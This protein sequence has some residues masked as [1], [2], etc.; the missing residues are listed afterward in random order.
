MEHLNELN[1]ANDDFSLIDFDSINSIELL[2]YYKL[3]CQIAALL[4]VDSEYVGISFDNLDKIYTNLSSRKVLVKKPYQEAND[5]TAL[6]I[7]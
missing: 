4:T 7:A 5:E 1:I 2:K 3:R 6:R